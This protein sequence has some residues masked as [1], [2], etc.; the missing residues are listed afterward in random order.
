LSRGIIEMVAVISLLI[1]P[2]LLEHFGREITFSVLGL[3]SFA[4]LRQF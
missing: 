2:I 3:I 4:V 1:G